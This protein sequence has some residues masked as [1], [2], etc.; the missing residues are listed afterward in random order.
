MGVIVLSVMSFHATCAALVKS[1][2]KARLFLIC[3]LR[4]RIVFAFSVSSTFPLVN[5]VPRCV[6]ARSRR[7]QTAP[8]T[9]GA[10][11]PLPGFSS[12]KHPKLGA[13]HLKRSFERETFV[14]CFFFLEPEVR[15]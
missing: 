7:L 9:A 2:L 14:L 10:A 1:L 5:T 6:F 15:T 11:L 8:H 4:N 12:R 3:S 13:I